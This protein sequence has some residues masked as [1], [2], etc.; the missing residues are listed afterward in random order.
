MFCGSFVE[1][2]SS[3]MFRRKGFVEL[4]SVSPFFTTADCLRRQRLKV[5][6]GNDEWFSL[7]RSHYPLSKRRSVRWKR[8]IVIFG[9]GTSFSVETTSRPHWQIILSASLTRFFFG[10]HIAAVHLVRHDSS[11][12]HGHAEAKLNWGCQPARPLSILA[13]GLRPY[14]PPQLPPT[15]KKLADGL[16]LNETWRVGY[17]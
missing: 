6:F 3:K 7:A 17:R 10:G 14:P 16:K 4:V 2:V 12:Q 15:P 11:S 1:N 13:G 8:H 5:L 9:N